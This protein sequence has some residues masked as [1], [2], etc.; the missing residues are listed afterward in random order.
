MIFDKVFNEI[1]EITN[2]KISYLGDLSAKNGF[3]L[4]LE[5]S[6]FLDVRTPQEYEN[7]HPKG[8]I[9]VPIY[10]NINGKVIENLNFVKDIDNIT[11]NTYNKKIIII[12]KA[13]I[14]SHY[15]SNLLAKSNYNSVYNITNGFINDWM[16]N[17]LPTI[18]ITNIG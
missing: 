11:N 15:A 10:F 18:S 6:I 2:E 12:C 17:N 5:D 7:L 13:G 14:K 8:A 16:V 9:N 3:N 4:S 1:N